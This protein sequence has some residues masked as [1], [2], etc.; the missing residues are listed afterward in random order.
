MPETKSPSTTGRGTSAHLSGLAGARG[1]EVKR[2]KVTLV[3][4]SVSLMDHIRQN[5]QVKIKTRESHTDC[6]SER[7]GGRRASIC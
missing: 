5:I 3:L 2:K 1:W 4:W 6:W 7:K